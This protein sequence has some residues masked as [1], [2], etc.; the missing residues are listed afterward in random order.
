MS[1]LRHLQ[2]QLIWFWRS[3]GCAFHQHVQTYTGTPSWFHI[4]AGWHSKLVFAFLFVPFRNEILWCTAAFML[5]VQGDWC[6]QHFRTEVVVVSCPIRVITR[7]IISRPLDYFPILIVANERSAGTHRS[8]Y[9]LT[10]TRYA[11]NRH[12]RCMSPF[13]ES[14]Q[15]RQ[16]Y[17]KSTYREG[18]TV[19]G[20]CRGR[21]I[22]PMWYINITILKAI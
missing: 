16:C 7:K 13:S 10:S 1:I 14:R 4:T 11:H 19:D 15:A 8:V 12:F 5:P 18:A 9:K 3:Q 22:P 17:K 2:R 21:N 20:T 6:S